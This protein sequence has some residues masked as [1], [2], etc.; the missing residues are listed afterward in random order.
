VAATLVIISA[1]LVLALLLLVNYAQIITLYEGLHTEVLGG[2]TVT[3][4]EIAFVPNFVMWVASWLIGPGFAIGIG[5]S[6]SPLATSLGPIPA[7]PI[8]GAIPAGAGSLGLV[9]VLV[10]VVIGFLSGALFR[11]RLVPSIGRAIVSGL[12]M[13]LTAGFVLGLLSWF[14]VGAAGPGRL[15]SVGPNPWF[16][17]LWAAIEIGVSA[18]IGVLAASR[19]TRDP[20]LADQVRKAPPAAS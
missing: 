5:S 6:V 14:S 10:P 7:I 19:S 13:G 2:A 12:G 8:L 11:P 16:I 17:A 9:A 15:A 1:A 3:L 20:G 18:T 4:A